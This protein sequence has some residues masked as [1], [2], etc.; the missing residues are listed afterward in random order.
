MATLYISTSQRSLYLY[1][2]TFSPLSA[3]THTPSLLLSLSLTLCIHNDCKWSNFFAYIRYSYCKSVFSSVSYVFRIFSLYAAC[4]LSI[5]N[6]FV[7]THQNPTFSISSSFTRLV[8]FIL[9]C[10][11]SSMRASFTESVSFHDACSSKI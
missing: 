2:S 8:L 6:K 3:L 5:E 4:F 9:P 7:Y 10:R 1:P 11:A